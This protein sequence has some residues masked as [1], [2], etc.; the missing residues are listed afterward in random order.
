MCRI[1]CF[2]FF[3]LQFCCNVTRSEN[4]YS[5]GVA[6]LSVFSFLIWFRMVRSVPRRNLRR[7]RTRT[8]MRWV[9]FVLC[10]QKSGFRLFSLF[11]L[12]S[13]HSTRHFLTAIRVERNHF[14]VLCWLLLFVVEYNRYVVLFHRVFSR[15][16]CCWIFRK[17]I[18]CCVSR[19]LTHR[20]R[21]QFTMEFRI[22]DIAVTGVLASQPDS[23]DIKIDQ[24]NLLY[25]G[26]VL[27][28]D[29]N[30]SDD[31]VCAARRARLLSLA[32][33]F[34]VVCAVGIQL[35]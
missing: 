11:L 31:R 32:C 24:A 18:L 16:L 34:C 7:M 17:S 14:D 33:T 23:R 4:D 29:A 3:F 8:T 15:F 30:V 9:A 27:V 19:L 12:V 26:H 21:L 28:E 35:W 5:T 1:C 25:C 6:L 2:C 13:H 20:R 22:E 10:Q